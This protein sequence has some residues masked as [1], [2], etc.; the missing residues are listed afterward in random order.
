MLT[1][2]RGASRRLRS[3]EPVRLSV[4]P[5]L[6]FAVALFFVFP[7]LSAP[8]AG[9][10]AL[11]RYS[12]VHDGG[13]LLLR[14][15]DAEGK[16]VSTEGQNLAM[17]PDLRSFTESGQALSGELEELYGSPESM[18]EAQVMQVRRRTLEESGGT[19][20]ATD[21]LILEP[22]GLLLLGSREGEAGSDVLFDRP[23]VLLPADLGPGKRWS[24]RGKAGPLHYELN[25]RVVGT[26]SFAGRLGDFDDCLF[27][28]TTLTLSG[29]D[30]EDDPVR[31]RDTYCAGVG[32]VESRELDE[33]GDTTRRGVVV[34]TDL[35]PPRDETTLSP[36]PLE[37]EKDV[38]GDPASWQLSHFGRLKPS[39]EATAGSIPPTYVRTDPPVVLA[40]AEEGD[41]VA[42]DAGG[43]QGRVRWR[44]HP[45]G[46]IYG[47]PA[48][49]AKTGRVF[50][51][52]TDKK[53]YA[54]DARGLFLWAF[55][56]GD[57]VASRPVVAG[58]T[59]VFGS[60]NRNIYGLDA[61]TGEERWSVSTGGPVVSSPA[62]E[63]GVVVVGSDDGAVYGLDPSTGEQ[64]W[65][66]LAGGAVEA[67][68]TVADGLAYVASRSGEL[69]ALDAGTGKEIWTSSQGK[70][71]RTAPAV[72]NREVFVVDDEHDLL[73]FDRQTGRK[74]WENSNGSYVG[75][76]LVV[77]GEL[78][79]SRADGHIE[80]LDLAGR[81]TGGWDGAAAGNPID[82]DQALALGP[83]VG[84][85]ALW[86]ATDK[87]SVIRL[88]PATRQAH[89]EP[90]WADPFS[91]RP[92]IGDVPQYTA[93]GYRGEALLLGVGNNVYLLDTDSGAARRVT[94]LEGASGSPSAEPVVVGDTLLAASG[95]ALAAVR[96][97]DGKELWKFGGGSGSRAPVVAGGSVLWLST[98]EDGNALDAL[99][100]DN[101]EKLWR[102]PLPGAGGVIS[103]GGT[104]YTN[105]A[106][107]FDL[108]TGETLW[109]TEGGDRPAN[110]GP[111]LSDSGDVL[112]VGSGAAGGEPGSVSAL[113]TDNG[114]ER[115]S[116]GLDDD[117]VNPT[118]R[119]WAS[120]GLV[121][122]PLLSGDVVALDAA[123]G[124][125]EWR[126]SP[127]VARLG[128]VTV[129]G[130][131]VWFALQDG[132]VL[133]LD[134]ASG[135]TVVRSNDYS[136][137]LGSTSVAQRPAFVEGTLVLGVGTYVL[138]FGVPEE[139]GGP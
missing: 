52:A 102:A 77:G 89:L 31:Y 79:V 3:S 123:T 4:V 118:D 110:G 107:A 130:G 139:V 36:A 93:T 106:A 40:A 25:G 132:E 54:L 28:R 18:E 34:S 68:V 87:A 8:S 47:P 51:G 29:P 15:Y 55:A 73:A 136:L 7:W 37:P 16:L 19:S 13:S 113:D 27:A 135:E 137:N 92:F 45:E 22:R 11:E 75:P 85:G 64:R 80:R 120:G 67:P 108:V 65:R 30:V 98:T 103:K 38:A 43:G 12:P 53:L 111:A 114:E 9:G 94:G 129:R 39:G 21:T 14:T 95:D 121:I 24:S 48:F 42:L 76:P 20:E 88:G 82:G 63:S 128:N 124:E 101:G 97:P 23:A 99:D 112:F 78:V 74:R 56:T 17:I 131:D 86:A 33:A 105:P 126:Y 41:L 6:V 58:D 116:V 134:A 119:L 61:D 62:F 83:T 84:G 71:L 32:L 122:A 72:S 96:L 127:P 138:G 1:R 109:R 35:L 57:N 59:V 100:L 133:A 69:T 125:E 49:D 10:T 2:L 44:F 70:V 46:N 26:G 5:V 104:A 90:K 91:D 115:W 66:Y 81:R 117:A 60:E 50:F